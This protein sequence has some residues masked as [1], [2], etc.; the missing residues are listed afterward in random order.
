MALISTLI[1][2][3]NDIFQPNLNQKFHEWS[4][5]PY[6]SYLKPPADL[7]SSSLGAAKYV[8]EGVASSELCQIFIPSEHVI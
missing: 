4:F 5:P 8:L 3:K 7:I 2:T 1:V 6:K